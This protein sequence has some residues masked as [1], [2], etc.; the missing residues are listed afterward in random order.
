[1]ETMGR[2][3]LS[4]P[5]TKNIPEITHISEEQ[6]GHFGNLTEPQIIEQAKTQKTTHP[7]LEIIRE[8][9]KLN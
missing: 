7:D 1:M 9:S 3:K 6:W 5:V 4:Y 2:T 8:E